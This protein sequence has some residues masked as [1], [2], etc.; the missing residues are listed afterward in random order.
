MPNFKTGLQTNIV[1]FLAMGKFTWHTEPHPT[2]LQLIHKNSGMTDCTREN[3]DLL[4][5]VI[6][7]QEA[8]LPWR[9]GSSH[10]CFCFSFPYR[11]SNSMFPV[12][13]HNKSICFT[14]KTLPTW[15][16]NFMSIIQT[17]IFLKQM[18]ANKNILEH[19][20]KYDL[21]WWWA[22][23]SYKYMAFSAYLFNLFWITDT[24]PFHLWIMALMKSDSIRTEENNLLA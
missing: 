6:Q 3:S 14:F 17:C 9:R 19:N 1:T 22:I 20:G 24:F 13:T 15:S 8:T 12:S 5:P 10:C 11:C 23:N 4:L 18:L 16:S 21:Q 2:F 7:K